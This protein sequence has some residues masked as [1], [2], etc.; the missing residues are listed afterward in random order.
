MRE[1]KDLRCIPLP[2][3]GEGVSS[4]RFGACSLHE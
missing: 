4:L 2:Q 1:H 3:L